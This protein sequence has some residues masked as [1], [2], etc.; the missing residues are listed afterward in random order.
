MYVCIYFSSLSFRF[1]RFTLQI[2]VNI[3][4]SVRISLVKETR[5]FLMV[6]LTDMNLT[7]DMR[8]DETASITGNVDNLDIS[9]RDPKDQWIKLLWVTSGM[10]AVENCF[11]N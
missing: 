9:F 11:E 8:S 7:C 3:T 10:R 2:V 4:K 5:A 6:A 1:V